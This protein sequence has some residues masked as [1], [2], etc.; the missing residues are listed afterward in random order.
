VTA[1]KHWRISAAIMAGLALAW[2]AWLLRDAWGSMG[3]RHGEVA[4]ATAG[5]AFLILLASMYLALPAYQL[6]VEKGTGKNLPH[7]EAARLYFIPQ[8]MKHLPGRFLGVAYQA[9]CADHIA[10]PLQWAAIN[11]G[12]TLLT[13]GVGLW[14]SY[15]IL[16]LSGITPLWIAAVAPVAALLLT[17][18]CRRW[19][20][21]RMKFPERLRKIQP[22]LDSAL[23]IL[24]LEYL[25]RGLLW[26]GASWVAYLGAWSA[27][28]LGLGESLLTGIELC[29]LYTIAWTLGFASLVTPS[30]LGVRELAFS[31]LASRYPAD[32]VAYVAIAARVALLM[33]DLVLGSLCLLIQRIR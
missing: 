4:Y 20:A 2:T 3:D 32:L 13:L 33:A 7:W 22:I 29:A 27:F 25:P 19:C 30:G 1:R 28:G 6:L 10:S 24:S 12:Y 21:H 9:V 18:I 31:L 8:I 23:T 11:I 5:V 15:L 26:L 17:S 16:A 14:V